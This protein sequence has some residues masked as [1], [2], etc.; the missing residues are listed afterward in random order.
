MRLLLAAILISLP[1]SA[2]AEV[3]SDENGK[4]WALTMPSPHWFARP[5]PDRIVV[6]LLPKE[7]VAESC[8]W[9]TGKAGEFGCTMLVPHLCTIRVAKE[10]PQEFRDAV[11]HH[12]LAHCHGW[13]G[14]HPT[15]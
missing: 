7:N 6:D 14:D 9:L 2:K 8:R 10:L 5:A 1:V 4:L 13:P 3:F 12:E 15:D 11:V